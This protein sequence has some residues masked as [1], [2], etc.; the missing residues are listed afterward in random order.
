MQSRAGE[1]IPTTDYVDLQAALLA[2][3]LPETSW[4]TIPI[5][6]RN[7]PINK[8]ILNYKLSVFNPSAYVK[9]EKQKKYENIAAQS[10]LAFKQTDREH[11]L[12]G[13]M[14]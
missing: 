2:S 6:T 13:M 8:Q 11:F 12:I 3:N 1:P 4:F 5:V 14:I 10:V 9:E 7:L